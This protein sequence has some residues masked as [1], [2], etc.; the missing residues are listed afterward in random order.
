MVLRN[1]FDRWCAW[2][3]ARGSCKITK[4]SDGGR[5]G[6]PVPYMERYYLLRIGGWALFLHRFWASDPEQPHCHPWNNVKMIL[7]GFYY[8]MGADGIYHQRTAWR[9]TYR[10]AE[11]FHRV[12]IPQAMEGK[13]WTLFAHGR[14]FRE[15]G[16]LDGKRWVPSPAN[17]R[18][19]VEYR[20]RLFPRLIVGADQ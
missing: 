19:S 7:A 15:W 2:M 12:V 17:Q 20:G 11:V 16:W 18:D 13:V 6:E 9:P 14:R 4:L 1:L 3:Q 10:S 5:S 8:E